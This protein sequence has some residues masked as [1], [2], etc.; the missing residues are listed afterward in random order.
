MKSSPAAGRKLSFD[1]VMEDWAEGMDYCAVPVPA[2]VT[3]ALGT[4]GLCWSWRG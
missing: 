4:K 2:T 1:A 3:D